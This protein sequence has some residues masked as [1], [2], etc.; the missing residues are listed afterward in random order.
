[1]RFEGR[2]VIVTGA[3][4]GLGRAAALRFAAEGASVVVA[5]LLAD[6]AEHV[7]AEAIAAGGVAVAQTVDIADE[8][9][10][11]AMVDRAVAEFGG[12]DVMYANAGVA[13]RGFGQ[14]PLE[15]L[16]LADWQF[17]LDVNLTGAFLSTK[18]ALRAMKERRRGSIVICSSAAGLT[19][20]PG[21]TAY[22]AAKHG[23]VGFVKA[24]AQSAG[25]WG[26]RVN[27]V[28]PAHGMASG[29]V[30]GAAATTSHEE[31]AGTWD[32]WASQIPLK[33]DQPPT[34]DDTASM[35][36]YLASDEARY[37]TGTSLPVTDGGTLSRVA[38]QIPS[39]VDQR[40]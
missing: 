18:H 11:A 33:L 23:V 14:V 3:G 8:D 36:L 19:S 29:F 7:A 12:L 13:E 21:W 17:C 27:A 1:M 5:D 26:V 32:P 16:S 40:P 38:L 24:A 10:V 15:E 6:R 4:S 9:A 30:T 37:M 28:C 39:H 2:S 31:S 34:L 20:Y 22:T 35:V 25:R